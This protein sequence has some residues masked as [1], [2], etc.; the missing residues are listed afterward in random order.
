MVGWPDHPKI[1]EPL[2]K[3]KFEEKDFGAANEIVECLLRIDPNDRKYLKLRAEILF[4]QRLYGDCIAVYSALLSN[5]KYGVHAYVGIGRSYQMLGQADEARIAF[6]RADEVNPN[7]VA[8]QYYISGRQI[9]EEAF[10]DKI[11]CQTSLSQELA[12]WAEVY[13]QNEMPD[14]A[15]IFYQAILE[16]DPEYFPA[17]IGLAEACS[18]LFYHADAM[19]I[20]QSL[21]IA[22]PWDAK[23]MLAIAR[24]FAWSKNYDAAISQYNSI[25][26]LNPNDPV[27]Y[28][29]KARTALWGKKFSLAMETYDEL[30][31]PP[32]DGLSQYLIQRSIRL[33]KRAKELNWNKR[34]MRASRAYKALLDFNPGNE[35]CLFDDAQVYYILGMCDR[36]REIYE[37]IL[38]I[39]PSHNIVKMALDRNENA[40]QLGIAGKFVLLEGDRIR[41]LFSIANC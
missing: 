16:S 34:Y 2:A 30:L 31:Q 5:R 10:V 24:V 21:L 36:S 29:E 1:L 41:N 11:I 38:N 3:L 14:K 18:I 25:I 6:Q 26:E 33:E 37:D 12:E 9:R 13:A 19:E 8:A 4:K 32:V 35:E 39:D 17:Q 15:L 23:L 22:F 28:R 20:Y 27:P 40:R 7:D